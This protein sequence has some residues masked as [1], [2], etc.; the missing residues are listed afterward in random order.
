MNKQTIAKIKMGK[1]DSSEEKTVEDTIAAL[2]KAKA[3]K[4]R[5][6]KLEMPPEP[7]KPNQ[8]ALDVSC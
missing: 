5:G 7:E 3:E 6:A 2:A 4:P 1:K 8:E